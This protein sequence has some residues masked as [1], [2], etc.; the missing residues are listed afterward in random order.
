[1][2]E[3]GCRRKRPLPTM[4]RPQPNDSFLFPSSFPMKAILQKLAANS[5]DKMD[6]IQFRVDE[7]EVESNG[8]QILAMR[9]YDNVK[10]RIESQQ[11]SLSEAG[12][13]EFATIEFQSL[14]TLLSMCVT[15]TGIIATITFST[16]DP[17]VFA[18]VID[19]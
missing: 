4:P 10:I 14:A 1:M 15:E 17:R 16:E 3:P 7:D 18:A 13:A 5:G 2:N 8:D 6:S 9:R 11:A 12:Q 19:R